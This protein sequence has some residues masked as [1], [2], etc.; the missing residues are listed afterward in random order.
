MKFTG[1]TTPLRKTQKDK[2]DTAPAK[3]T[4]K[5][6]GEIPIQLHEKLLD[7]S[8]WNYET[9]SEVITQALE[10]YLEDKEIK[11]RPEKVKQKTRPGRKARGN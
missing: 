8:F 11:P 7:Y 4:V 1:Q 10:N 9:H 5:V 3:E 2:T 6:S